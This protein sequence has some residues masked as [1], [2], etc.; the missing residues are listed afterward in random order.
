MD[1]MHATGRDLE[2]SLD[3]FL[4]AHERA[5]SWRVER[6]LKSSAFETTELVWFDGATG[7][8]L[9]PFVRKRINC[10]AGVGSAYE[11]L[12][13]AQRGRI[14]LSCVPRIV[15][16]VRAGDELTV[17]MEFIDGVTFADMVVRQGASARLAAEVMPRV[18]DAV[19][20]LHER[21]PRPLIHR[22]LTPSN[23]IVR[24]GMPIII[25]FGIA[26]AWRVGAQADTAHFGTRAYAPPEQYGFGQTDERSDVYALGKL[27]FFC[28]TGDEPAVAL[29]AHALSGHAVPEPYADIIERAAAFDPAARYASAR[30]MACAIRTASSTSAG[31][32][33][34]PAGL[35]DGR[36]YHAQLSTPMGASFESAA[37]A[38]V[39]SS[40]ARMVPAASSMSSPAGPASAV[41]GA[42]VAPIDAAS[43]ASGHPSTAGVAQVSAGRRSA[44]SRIVAYLAQRV[45]NGLGRV[46]NALVIAFYALLC[47]A[48][49]G[50]VL[51]PNE[52]DSA[53]PLWFLAFEYG[54]FAIAVF[55][56][57][58]Y[59]LL[60]KRRLFARHPRL[61]RT[62]LSRQLLYCAGVVVV[63]ILGVTIIGSV[64]GLL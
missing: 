20:E 15:E 38:L 62:S 7:G 50:A 31:A 47:V 41:S 60:D 6:V 35:Q 21:L 29:D 58:A 1:D 32:T 44:A 26:R 27:L 42:P 59:T 22:D 43:R 14:V 56:P 53:Y 57:I 36:T 51:Y 28:L 16:C 45:P 54:A 46:W 61:G 5:E 52:H 23:I 8:S 40:A 37:A 3:E 64:A 55:G 63:T 24:G 11:E 19:A 17:V 2:V 25:D 33:G 9:G 34:A 48:C 13:E 49:L 12:F 30:D 39:S 10:A 18:C 4:S